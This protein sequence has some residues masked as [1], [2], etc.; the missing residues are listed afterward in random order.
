MCDE[1]DRLFVLLAEIRAACGDN[2]VRMQPELVEHI[3][4]VYR[5]AQRYQLLRRGQHW[6]VISGIGDA[7]RADALDA[8]IDAAMRQEACDGI[9]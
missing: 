1:S 3:G 6:S 8:A 9:E 5:D 7:L 4:E 2:G